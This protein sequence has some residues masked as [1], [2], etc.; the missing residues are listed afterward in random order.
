MKLGVL[1][2]CVGDI[3]NRKKPGKCFL[4][5]RNI[6]SVCQIFFLSKVSTGLTFLLPSEQVR[7]GAMLLLLQIRPFH[8]L[9]HPDAMKVPQV[10]AGST[11]VRRYRIRLF[12]GVAVLAVPNFVV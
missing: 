2:E 1:D 10:L 7:N 9:Y 11:Q 5:C 12:R 6:N 3:A 8:M 4:E